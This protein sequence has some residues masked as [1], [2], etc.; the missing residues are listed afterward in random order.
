MKE[1]LQKVLASR[2]VASRRAAE[3]LIAAGAVR[4]NGSVAGVGQSVDPDRDTIEV[5]GQL[6]PPTLPQVYLLLN[7]PVGYVSSRRSTHGE[8]T[9]MSLLPGGSDVYPVGRLDK[10]TSGLLLLTNDGDWANVVTH[11]RYEVEKQYE[12]Q[13]RGQPSRSLLDALRRGVTLPDGSVTA[14]AQVEVLHSNARG[15]TVSVTVVEGKKRQIRLMMSAIGHPLVALRRVRVGPIRLGNL[16]VGRWR[17][18]EAAEVEGIRQYVHR[19][20]RG[21]T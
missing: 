13:I 15:T 5:S 3:G 16:G 6:L 17:P 12:V 20:A 14:P 2:G 7:K 11:P 1:R 8:L 18:L 21:G 10:D 19:S 9:V 4:V